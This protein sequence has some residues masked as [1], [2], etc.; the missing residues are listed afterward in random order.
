MA[1]N[2]PTGAPLIAE[3]N[4]LL[5]LDHD[6]VQAYTLAIN[7]LESPVFRRT[8]EEYRGE[9]ERH[10]IELTRLIQG[11]GGTPI[12]APHIPSGAFKL[13]VQAAGTLGGDRA[14]LLAFKSNEGQARDKYRRHAERPHTPDVADVLRRAANDE[15]KHYA[16][17]SATLNQLDAG[18]DT[19]I[20]KVEGA[21]ETVHGKVADV[22]ESAE[23]KVMQSVDKLRG[24]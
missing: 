12:E 24:K 2:V 15:E 11:S 1:D 10:I 20:G 8:L 5:Q 6:A 22:M 19:T 9:H 7:A 23:R 14:V 13:A 4:D 21:F 18:R 16:W 17:V 3:L